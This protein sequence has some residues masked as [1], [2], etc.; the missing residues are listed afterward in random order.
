MPAL[1]SVTI[2][3]KNPDKFKEYVAQVPAT[4]AP[5]GAKMLARGKISKMLSGEIPHQIEAVFEFPDEAALQAWHDS[6]A[7]QA[8]VPLR[9]EAADMTLAIVE[10]F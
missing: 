8:L 4:M 9:Q 5:H 7:Y 2:Q 10:P 6:D 1:L 3:L